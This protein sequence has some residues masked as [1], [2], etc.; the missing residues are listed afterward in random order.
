[1]HRVAEKEPLVEGRDPWMPDHPAV[2]D[3]ARRAEPVRAGPGAHIEDAGAGV[4]RR[5]QVRR[6]VC[7]GARGVGTQHALVVSAA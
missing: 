4:Q 1:M 2:I 6:R 3:V 5:H 7:D